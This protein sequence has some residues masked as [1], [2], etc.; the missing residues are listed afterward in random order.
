MHITIENR[1]SL[2]EFCIRL[3]LKR[4]ITQE[5]Q[6]LI[7]SLKNEFRSLQH[8]EK[9][10]MKEI[11][12]KTESINKLEQQVKEQQKINNTKIQKAEEGISNE[13]AEKNYCDSQV[14]LITEGINSA[15]SRQKSEQEKWANTMTELIKVQKDLGTI[16]A[17]HDLLKSE[18]D[19]LIN[20]NDK[21]LTFQRVRTITCNRCYTEIVLK[22]NDRIIE[23]LS[24]KEKTQMIAGV[25]AARYIEPDN[26]TRS[27]CRCLIC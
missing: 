15:N 13:I 10:N 8:R 18:A 1:Q 14:I 27:I 2:C 3:E 21:M 12:L 5:R 11:S 17:D 4:L 6:D 22:F 7:T 23:I 26:I 20:E 16:Q 24:R 25:L 19:L 9:A